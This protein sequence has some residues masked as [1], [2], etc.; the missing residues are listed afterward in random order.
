MAQISKNGN[1]L[2]GYLTKDFPITKIKASPQALSRGE[3]G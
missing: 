1:V 3:G 2:K